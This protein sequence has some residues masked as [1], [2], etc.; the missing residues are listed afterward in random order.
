MN[1][2]T[3]SAASS[4]KNASPSRLGAREQLGAGRR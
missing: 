4:S 2:C 3:S 1:E